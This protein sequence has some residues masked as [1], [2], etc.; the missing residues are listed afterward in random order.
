VHRDPDLEL[1]EYDLELLLGE[2]ESEL[3]AG[4][5][6]GHLSVFLDQGL[7]DKVVVKWM[8]IRQHIGCGTIDVVGWNELF[9]EYFQEPGLYLCGTIF[10]G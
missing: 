2:V 1:V 3:S 6:E 10:L 7:G 5:V 9:V 8:N 4:L